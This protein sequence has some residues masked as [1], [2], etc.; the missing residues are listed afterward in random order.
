[1]D[2]I[3]S[4]FNFKDDEYINLRLIFK[5]I[6]SRKKIFGWISFISLVTSVIYSFSLEKLYKGS[7]EIVLRDQESKN[8]NFSG[9]Q[10]NSA[11]S[12][13]IKN[14]ADIDI[15]TQVGI[16]KSPS[17]LMPIFNYVKNT[18]T[19]ESNNQ[20]MTYKK[21]FK[22][23]L[24]INLEKGT[25]ILEITYTDNNSELILN[26]LNKISDT[27]QKYSDKERYA[28]IE[29]GLLYLGEQ[30]KN[31]KNKS[32]ES[33]K[34][35]QEF[36]LENDLSIYLVGDDNQNLNLDGGF[37][38]ELA[39]KNKL[40]AINKY[41]NKLSLDESNISQKFILTR[42]IYQNLENVDNSIK[43]EVKTI[44]SAENRLITLRSIY[45]E[46]DKNVIEQ[47]KRILLLKN[48]FN[49]NFYNLLLGLKNKL[50]IDIEASSKPKEIYLEYKNLASKSLRDEKI[51]QNLENEY[52]ILSLERSKLDSPWELITKPTL[53]P[54]SVTTPKTIIVFN[55]LIIGL[56]ISLLII[57]ILERYL[58]LV[59]RI[60]DF[61]KGF[62][63]DLT[64]DLL[65]QNPDSFKESISIFSNT[66]KEKNISS[67]LAILKVGAIPESVILKLTKSMK[68]VNKDINIIT[69]NDLSKLCKYKNKLIAFSPGTLNYSDLRILKEKIKLTKEKFLGLLLLD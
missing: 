19:N 21:W 57:F 50:L 11:I 38:I 15:N 18:K 13:L 42:L 8:L 67:E 65:N 2:N 68:S 59:Y 34:D 60:E 58:D 66:L 22:K 9:T 52:Q 55:G 33:I 24:N 63:F 16:L 20:N 32:S 5:I 39:L 53:T 7:F 12:S 37:N 35:F 69:F 40:N 47:K 3:N 41:L 61:K 27:Y 43:T 26:T 30:I 29:K 4:S 31:Y 10:F 56:F 14:S 64:L 51:L 45:T 54:R 17:V 36:A 49:N 28:G 44:D 25:K 1:M 23:S 62:E 6:L 46:K 48:E